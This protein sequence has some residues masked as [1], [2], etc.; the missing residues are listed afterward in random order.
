MMRNLGIPI[1]TPSTEMT[2]NFPTSGRTIPGLQNTIA[3][4]R[5]MVFSGL[6]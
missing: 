4:T 5:N 6:G 1:F 2:L 3:R